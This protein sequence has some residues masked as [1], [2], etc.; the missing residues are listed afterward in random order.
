M[1]P[2]IGE[3]QPGY[4]EEALLVMEGIMSTTSAA[5]NVVTPQGKARIFVSLARAWASSRQMALHIH[6]QGCAD[7]PLY[8][9]VCELEERD[10]EQC[11]LSIAD[12]FSK[13]AISEDEKREAELK[14]RRQEEE[15]KAA[16]K[17]KPAKRKASKRKPTKTKNRH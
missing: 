2:D 15:K 10:Q 13:L 8:D 11:V 16:K 17:K 6:K 12:Y 3:V 7:C 4:G 14:F 1:H 9:T 5:G